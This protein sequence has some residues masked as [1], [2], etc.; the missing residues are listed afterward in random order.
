MDLIKVA[1]VRDMVKIRGLQTLSVVHRDCHE[2]DTSEQEQRWL[3]LERQTEVVLQ[4]ETSKPRHSSPWKLN[5]TS[6][7]DALSLLPESTP[8]RPKGMSAGNTS[9]MSALALTDQ[10]IPNNADD[11]VKF[12]FDQPEEVF[13]LVQNALRLKRSL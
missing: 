13:D 2:A 6:I 4:R 5:P 9:R 11:R 12:F 7:H 3:E 1:V 8:S 10:D